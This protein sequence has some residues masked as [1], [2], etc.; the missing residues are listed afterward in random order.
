[1]NAAELGRMHDFHQA[2]L[3]AVREGLVMLDGGRRIVLAN[4]GARELLGFGDEAVGG[5]WRSSVCRRRSRGRCS[6]PSRGWTRCI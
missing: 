3:H 5:P 6:P 4:D 2:A 1:M